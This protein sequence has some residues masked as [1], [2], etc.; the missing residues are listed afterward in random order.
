MVLYKKT[1]RYI[2][3]DTCISCYNFLYCFK[4]KLIMILSMLNIIQF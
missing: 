2:K 3:E 1:V 4:V